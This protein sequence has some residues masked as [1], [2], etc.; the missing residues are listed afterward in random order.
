MAKLKKMVSA[1]GSI[2]DLNSAR[3]AFDDASRVLPDEATFPP[4]DIRPATTAART[5]LLRITHA[6]K[7]QEATSQGDVFAIIHVPAANDFAA[8]MALN[9][10]AQIESGQ[11]FAT[12]ADEG[13]W[14]VIVAMVE[15]VLGIRVD[16]VAEL[17]SAALG[18]VISELGGVPVYSRAAFSAGGT[19]FAEGTNHLDATT[20]GIFTSADPIDDAGQTRTR[21]Q[22]AVLRALIQALK[23]GGLAKDPN[24][25]ASVLGHFASG[26]HHDAALTTVELAKIAKNLR[27][28]QADDIAVVTIPTTSRREDN[29][30]VSIDFDAEATP[31][32]KDAMAGDHLPAFFK[33]LVSLG[34]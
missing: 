6:A 30:T 1:V 20:A 15:D 9:P 14:P 21:N 8:V 3:A 32:L 29:G 28:L 5:L 12:I 23:S 26:I 2:K 34:Y 4:E 22:R 19:D 13:G 27:Q 11:S 18:R 7:A 16:H 10:S 31:A 17:E 25:A 33:Y 24:K